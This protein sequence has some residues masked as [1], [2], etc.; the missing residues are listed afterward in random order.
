[1]FNNNYSYNK[2]LFYVS[3]DLYILYYRS[4]NNL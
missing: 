4:V 3:F 2:L 1:M